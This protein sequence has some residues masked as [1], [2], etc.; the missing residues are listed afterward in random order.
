MKFTAKYFEATR[1]AF[2][3]HN[4]EKVNLGHIFGYT[5]GATLNDL[6][7]TGFYENATEAEKLRVAKYFYPNGEINP[8]SEELKKS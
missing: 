5:G 2:I 4:G 7:D 6:K 8:D 1:K 3:L